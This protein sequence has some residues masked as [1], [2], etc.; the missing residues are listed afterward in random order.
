MALPS[1]P[2]FGHAWFHVTQMA[3]LAFTNG[4]LGTVAVI[5][6]PTHVDGAG[7]RSRAST[8]GVAV[9]LFGVV[10]AQWTAA[11][12]SYIAKGKR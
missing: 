10:C 3:L 5:H 4:W 8:L 9:A 12:I 1:T 7:A 11:L 6:L 2:V